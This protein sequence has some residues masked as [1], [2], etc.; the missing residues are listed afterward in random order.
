MYLD[1]GENGK[2]YW[3]HSMKDLDLII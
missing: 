3:E 2:V 1:K